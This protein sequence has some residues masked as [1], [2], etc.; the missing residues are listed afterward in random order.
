MA[1]FEFRLAQLSMGMTDGE[2][3]QWYKAEGDHVVA[4]EPLLEIDTG[5]VSQDVES[6]ETGV[7]TRHVAQTGETLE[8]G[9]TLCVIT[10]DDGA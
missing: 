7:L 8:V 3:V 2:V 1:Q 4:G 6:P 10:L 9:G 5:K